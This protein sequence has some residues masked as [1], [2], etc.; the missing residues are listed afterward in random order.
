MPATTSRNDDGDL[1]RRYAAPMRPH[2]YVSDE[3][4][5]QRLQDIRRAATTAQQELTAI[6]KRLGQDGD[7]EGAKYLKGLIKDFLRQQRA[8]QLWLDW[9]AIETG[10]TSQADWPVELAYELDY[11]AGA[12]DLAVN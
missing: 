5:I 12:Y 4:G 9:L 7:R 8:A 1:V 2:H 3:R 6:Q 10:S 11:A